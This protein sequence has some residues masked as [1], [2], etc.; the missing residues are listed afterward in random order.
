MA[1]ASEQAV[2]DFGPPSYQY[3]TSRTVYMFWFNY[4]LMIEEN[5]YGNYSFIRL[6]A[7]KKWFGKL[8]LYTD[9]GKEL[10]ANVQA[11]WEMSQ[12]DDILLE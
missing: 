6:V 10:P 2:Q 9:E 8:K 3:D 12:V 1:S 11:K 4:S 5:I 7:K